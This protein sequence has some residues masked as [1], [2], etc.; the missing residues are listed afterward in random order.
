MTAVN[1]QGNPIKIFIHLRWNKQFKCFFPE[2]WMPNKE[3]PLKTNQTFPQS[4][5]IFI[6]VFLYFFNIYPNPAIPTIFDA[7]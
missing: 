7:L 5:S 3:L 2:Q 4:P 6:F 1:K